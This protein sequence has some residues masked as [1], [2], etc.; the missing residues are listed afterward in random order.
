MTGRYGTF[1]AEKIDM[2]RENKTG[3]H[4]LIVEDDMT[5]AGGLCRALQSESIDTVS[6]GTLREAGIVLSQRQGTEEKFSL[7]ILDINLP[8]GNGLDFLQQIKKEYDICVI[9][10]TANDME[11]DIVTG[12][13]MGAD[14]YITKPFSLAVLRARVA[15]QL[16][17]I[18]ER[19]T[20]SFSREICV[21]QY[22][23]DFM[24]MKFY[25]GDRQ[26]ELSKTEQK[27]LRILIEN[28]G[29]TVP[30]DR[31]FEYIWSEGEEFVEENALS[32]TVKR[33]R[34]KLEAQEIIKTVYGIGY[35]WVMS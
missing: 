12:L 28:R 18:E 33:L 21:G 35:T 11:T 9:I 2:E 19:G 30:R 8:D 6:C 15:L 1:K 13:E 34:D 25:V 14:D 16:R 17:R 4:I 7:I 3:H 22:R 24:H 10:L 32:V 20:Q 23:F 31:L 27:L 26:V 29:L 5:L